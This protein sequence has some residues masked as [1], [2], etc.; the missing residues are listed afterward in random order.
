M[1]HL[2]TKK[3]GKKKEKQNIKKEHMQRTSIK[4]EMVHSQF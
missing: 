1:Q 4:K 3:K 2:R